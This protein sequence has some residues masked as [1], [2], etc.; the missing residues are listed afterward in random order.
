MTVAIDAGELVA[1][2]GVNGS[3]KSTLMRLMAGTLPT[4]SGRALLDGKDI[5]RYKPRELARK[6]AVLHQHAPAVPGLTARQLVRQGRY[7]HRGL[8]G[9]LRDV[10][11][12]V[13]MTALRDAGIVDLADRE[14][15]QLSGGNVSGYAWLWHWPSRPACCCSTSR[16]RTERQLTVVMVLHD[17]NQAARFTDR[18]VVVDRGRIVGDGPP[19]TVVTS[20]LLRDV[21]G[22]EGRR[23]DTG[24]AVPYFIH[25]DPIP[26][27]ENPARPGPNTVP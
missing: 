27:R 10:D 11:D 15:V 3:G 26:Q 8:I 16:P 2:V 23:A 14:V 19:A 9:M 12:K 21:F 20:Q 7:P 24:G 5:S 1:L 18:I 22:V 6:V 13:C 17:L 25:Q 4:S